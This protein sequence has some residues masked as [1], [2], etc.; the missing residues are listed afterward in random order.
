MFESSHNKDFKIVWH[1]T[2]KIYIGEWNT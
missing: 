1:Y 2:G